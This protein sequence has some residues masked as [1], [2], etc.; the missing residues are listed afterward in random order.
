MKINI[1]PELEAFIKDLGEKAQQV[2]DTLLTAD[3]KAKVIQALDG[4]VPASTLQQI[5]S[6]LGA[7]QVGS[8]YSW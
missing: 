2:R 6:L 3:S 7:D 5:G 8:S 1:S 4:K